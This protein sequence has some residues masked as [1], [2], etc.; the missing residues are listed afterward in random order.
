[1]R[2][3]RT[4][5]AVLGFVSTDGATHLDDAGRKEQT[6]TLADACA[7]RGWDLVGL[8][9][10]VGPARRCRRPALSYAIERLRGGDASCLAVVELGRLC[11]SVADLR[12][13][14][15]S[16]ER[17]NARLV[18]LQPPIDT[19]VQS[20]RD[21]AR[22]ICAVSD[23]ERNRA[24]ERSRKALAVARE[25]GATQPTIQPQ[26]RRQIARM[27][28]AGMTLQAIVDELNESGVPTVRGGI[29]WRVS[30]VQAAIGYKRPVHA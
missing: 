1:M 14:F 28:G 15:E 12:Q 17:V 29:E 13:V 18:S 24:A 10:E 30:S 5:V 6:A 20:G 22:I 4:R 7:R 11:R 26:L 25:K 8:V 2:T 9:H 16:L 21:A 19:G 27:R 3:E 23:W